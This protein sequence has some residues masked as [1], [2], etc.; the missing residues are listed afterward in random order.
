MTANAILRLFSSIREL[1]RP[2]AAA[3]IA[4]AL[5]TSLLVFGGLFLFVGMEHP[6]RVAVHEAGL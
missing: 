1:R 6:P 5:A 2:I 4:F 3:P